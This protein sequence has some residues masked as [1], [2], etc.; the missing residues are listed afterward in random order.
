MG[1]DTV[2]KA[3]SAVGGAVWLTTSA[4]ATGRVATNFHA[5]LPATPLRPGAVAAAR[6]A[7][8]VA[9]R[10]T[11]PPPPPSSG[12]AG[13]GAAVDVGEFWDSDDSESSGGRSSSASTTTQCAARCSTG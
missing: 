9:A 1:L 4:A 12:A 3:V 6:V 8:G 13:Y 5:R 10:P 11:T 2:A 7:E